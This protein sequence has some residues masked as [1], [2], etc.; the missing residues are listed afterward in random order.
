MTVD[1]L[2]IRS[3][4]ARPVLAPMARPLRTAAGAI[5]AAPLVLIDLATE[6]GVSGRAYIF[7]Y[8]PMTLAPLVWLLSEMSEAL[9]GK[10]VAPIERMRESADRFRLLGRQGLVGMALAGVDMA[11]WDALGRAHGLG[12]AQLLGGSL[13]PLPAYDSFGAV[14]PTADRRDLEASLDRG[15]RAIKIKLGVG[16]LQADMARVAGVRDIIGPE[17][18]LMVDYN[19]SLTAPEAVRRID[20]LARYDVAWV[21]EPVDAGDLRGHAA[22]RAASPVPVQTGENWWSAG[23]MARAIEA[24][25]CDY[26]MPDLMR[27]GGITGWLSAMG[28]A[29][30]AAVP[31]SSH[32]FVETSA[33]ALAVTPT[34]HWLEFLDKAAAVLSEP[35]AVE[36]GTVRPRGPGLGMDWDEAAVSRYL[37]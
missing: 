22:V 16:P 33:H 15:F 34:A 20:A 24:G 28:T 17:V 2:V 26:A 10:T 37:Q 30:G 25:A 8:A 3:L 6:A 18:A 5:P 31:V 11:L 9:I 1:P 14:D 35:M 7:G 23:D 12:V 13:A 4:K 21:E 36:G 27:I 32:A 29:A 19:Q